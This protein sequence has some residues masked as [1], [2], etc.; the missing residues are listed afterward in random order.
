MTRF[1]RKNEIVTGAASGM[2]AACA[3]MLARQGAKV[4]VAD[5]N[6]RGAEAQAERIPDEWRALEGARA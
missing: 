3:A 4:V 1:S 5:V 2:G 6:R